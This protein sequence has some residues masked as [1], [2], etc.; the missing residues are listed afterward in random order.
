[1]VSELLTVSVPLL[2][3]VP[4]LVL[5]DRFKAPPLTLNEC[6]P[7]TKVAPARSSVP[8]PF[9]VSPSIEERLEVIVSVPLP[10]VMV[11]EPRVRKPPSRV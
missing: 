11:L 2:E 8:S 9:L 6:V 7:V 5:A 4:T 3:L 10:V 1:M